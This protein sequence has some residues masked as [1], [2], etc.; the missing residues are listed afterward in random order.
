MNQFEVGETAICSV[1]VRDEDGAL[2]APVT[3]MKVSI[4]KRGVFKVTDADM[5]PD[6]TGNYHYDWLTDETGTFMVEFT[7]TDN[8]RVSKTRDRFKVI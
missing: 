3:S 7:A 8:A 4:S 2:V 6:S 5:T 1:E